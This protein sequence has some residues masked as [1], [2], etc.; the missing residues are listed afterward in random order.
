MKK[1]FLAV[2]LLTG[3]LQAEVKIVK[4]F[5]GTAHLPPAVA[6]YAPGPPQSWLWVAADS[7]NPDVEAIAV[8]L[9]CVGRNETR[10]FTYTGRPVNTLFMDLTPESA[11][12]LGCSVTAAA[13]KVVEATTEKVTD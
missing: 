5:G 10:V 11:K 4:L 9:N 7:S 12:Q 6:I 1:V 8:T 3:F 13:I 2:F